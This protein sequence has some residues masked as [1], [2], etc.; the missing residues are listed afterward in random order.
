VAFEIGL[1]LTRMG[2]RPPDGEPPLMGDAHP[3]GFAQG[4]LY[5]V[6]AG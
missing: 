5:E 3:F 6:F 1:N 4:K 2:H